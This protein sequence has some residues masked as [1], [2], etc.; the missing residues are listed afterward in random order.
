MEH[1][2]VEFDNE[3]KPA[4]PEQDL[5]AN[6]TIKSQRDHPFVLTDPKSGNS[7]QI[8]CKYIDGRNVKFINQET[9]KERK[10]TIQRPAQ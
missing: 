1:F 6:E 2:F 8:I 7:Y 9:G 3:Y 4:L 5:I 10:A